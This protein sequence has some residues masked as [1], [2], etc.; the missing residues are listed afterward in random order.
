MEEGADAQE[1]AILSAGCT[2]PFGT[3][4]EQP[5]S[6]VLRRGGLPGLPG[7]AG[8]G[9]E[10]LWLRVHAYVLMTNPVHLLATPL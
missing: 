10:T 8:G 6:R 9:S 7:V 2:G 4:W 5:L 3:A 1:T